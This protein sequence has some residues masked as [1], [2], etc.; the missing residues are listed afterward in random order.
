MT[1]TIG[2]LAGDS[3]GARVI[4]DSAAA[5]DLSGLARQLDGLVRRFQV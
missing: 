3:S 2:E 1:S 5:Q 4:T